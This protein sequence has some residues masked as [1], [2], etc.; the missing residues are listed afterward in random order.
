M[1]SG[2][3]TAARAAVCCLLAGLLALGSSYFD[4]PTGQPAKPISQ[5]VRL[6]QF[7]QR[8]QIAPPAI[9]SG[10]RVDAAIDHQ[11]SRRASEPAYFSPAARQSS[12]PSFKFLGKVTEGDETLVLLYGGGRTLAV[13][14]VGPVDDDYVVDAIGEAYVVL[15]DVPLGESQVIQLTAQ[16]P[17]I[18][19]GW[20][21][22]NT[23][24]D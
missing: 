12:A 6:G 1:R 10:A 8:S 18:E 23:P 7:S 13:R 22:E 24:R 19:T 21:A 9:P 11:G 5:D 16:E 2:C 20:S 17:T 15:R 4:R 14:G 3:N